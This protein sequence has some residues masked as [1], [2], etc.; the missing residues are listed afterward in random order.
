M[1]TANKDNNMDH[2]LNSGTLLDGRYSIECVLGEGGFG[3]TYCAENTRIGIKV[4]IKELFWR[5]AFFTRCGNLSTG[6]RFPYR[7]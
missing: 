6:Y 4:A 5:G 1:L 2:K 7:R 3:I